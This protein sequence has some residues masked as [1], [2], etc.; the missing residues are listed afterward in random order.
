MTPRPTPRNRLHDPLAT[1]RRVLRAC[2]AFLAVL[3]VTI[4]LLAATHRHDD[5][6]AAP[7][8]CVICQVAEQPG[9]TPAPQL[10]LTVL[11][12]AVSTAAD[13]P[14]TVVPVLRLTNPAEARAPPA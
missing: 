13:G 8:S 2:G 11:P 10:D 14:T 1:P 4:S 3:T 7:I 12:S 5:D 9:A 6:S